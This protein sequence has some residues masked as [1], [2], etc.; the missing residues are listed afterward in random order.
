[1]RAEACLFGLVILRRTK[2]EKPS[3]R[4]RSL[5]DRFE[6]VCHALDDVCLCLCFRGKTWRPTKM[7]IRMI[8]RQILSRFNV[9][10]NI[11]LGFV[12]NLSQ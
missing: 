5:V 3:I 10:T 1:M 9:T 2:S 8:Y 7:L 4:L 6:N 11:V 12:R